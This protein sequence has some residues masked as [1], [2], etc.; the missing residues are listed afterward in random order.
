MIRIPRP[1]AELRSGR[2]VIESFPAVQLLSDLTWFDDLSLWGILCRITLNS[3]SELVPK[4]TDWW[5]TL[6]ESYPHGRIVVRPAAENGLEHTFAHQQYNGRKH[7]QLPW[8]D[9]DICVRT[10]QFVFAKH[11]LDPD[12]IGHT[13]RLGWYLQRAIEWL[14]AAAAGNLLALGDPFEL[15]DFPGATSPRYF[16]AHGETAETY[17]VWTASNTWYGTAELVAIGPRRGQHFGVRRFFDGRD[18]QVLS[19]RWGREI[20]ESK[21]L[22]PNAIWLRCDN[23]PIT[24]PY[25]AIDTWGDLFGFLRKEG[26]ETVF[27]DVVEL[28]R[29]G[30]SHLLLVG[31]PIPRNVGQAACQLHWQPILLP[32]LSNGTKY[33]KGFRANRLGYWMRDKAEFFIA[34]KQPD[35]HK[36]G[37][38]SREETSSRGRLHPSLSSLKVLVIG[39]GAVGSAVVELLV[40]ADAGRIVVCDGD[41]VEHGNLCRHTARLEDLGKNKAAVVAERLIGVHSHADVQAIPEYFPP[42]E[43]TLSTI[44]SDCDLIIDCTGDDETLH[45]LARHQWKSDKIFCSISLSYKAVRT[46]VFTGRGRSFPLNDFQKQFAPW[47]QKD[48]GEFSS[49]ELLSSGIGCWHPAFPAR[50]DDVWMMAAVAVRRL[51]E[52]V[53]AEEAA[54]ILVTF[55][56]VVEDGGFQGVRRM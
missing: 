55:E 17:R 10:P 8:R 12:P 1:T 9:G 5:I 3:A 19:Y 54:S 24:V 32:A 35:W 38:W 22:A 23:I 42:A 50:I 31:F 30:Q 14:E 2:R 37:N 7:P 26:R 39:A 29:D 18:H 11:A 41:D 27:Q 51:E 4:E 34:G 46:Y 45:D 53:R 28:A 40:R 49:A 13:A 36:A 15:P 21:R 16:V 33:R 44:I 20:T 47:A 43:E 25:Q 6:E 48:A 52:A 56:Q